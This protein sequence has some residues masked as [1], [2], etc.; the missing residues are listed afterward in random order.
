R[1]VYQPVVDLKTR[2]VHHYEALSRFPDGANTFETVTFSEDLGL[3]IEL[4]L[5]VCRRAVEAIMRSDKASVAVNVSGRSV[6]NEGFRKALLDVAGR[7]GDARSQLLFELTES[8]A[9]NDLAEA[10]EFLSRLRSAGHAI[11]LDDFGAGATAYNYM[12]R[13][14]ADFVKID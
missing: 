11:C 10:E 13:F 14:D 12:R 9:V 5:I 8:A 1:L 2:A 6:Q 3:I 7:L 4:D